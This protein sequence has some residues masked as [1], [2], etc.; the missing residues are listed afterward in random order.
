MHLVGLVRVMKIISTLVAMSILMIGS[1]ALRCWDGIGIINQETNRLERYLAFNETDCD[2]EAEACMTI[3]LSLTNP[4]SGN[5]T[6]IC[7]PQCVNETA[8][9]SISCNDNSSATYKEV[10][11]A[12]IS[13]A[14][15]DETE[16]KC[17]LSFCYEDLCNT[18]QTAQISLL[19]TTLIS[20]YQLLL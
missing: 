12:L 19:V 5:L 6:S 1:S 8:K 4:E 17:E 3:E 20:L 13:N 14:E 9:E 2:S 16:L 15:Q 18:G 11:D 7:F 10:Y